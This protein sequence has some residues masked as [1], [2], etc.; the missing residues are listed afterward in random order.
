MAHSGLVLA[1]VGKFSGV[2]SRASHV[3]RL[4][5]T[6]S[7]PPF[8]ASSGAVE[9]GR[10]V[11]AVGVRALGKTP[12][13]R[14]QFVAQSFRV[15]RVMKTR[16]VRSVVKSMVS[17]AVLIACAMPVTSAQ[18]TNPVVPTLV[19]FSGMLSSAD[20]KPLTGIVGVT[21]ALYQDSG[22][23][24][25]LWME[26][27]NVQPDKNGHYSVQLGAA[28]S[29]GLPASVFASGEARWLGVQVQGE[30]EQPRVMLL[31]VPYALKAGDA[32]TLGEK[33]ASA[34][35]SAPGNN[36]LSP[37]TVGNNTLTGKGTKDYVPLWLSGSKLGNSKIFQSASGDLGVGTT[38]PAANLDVNGTTDIRNTLS[39]FPSGSA[40]TLSINGTAFSV[41]NT[42]TVTF[43]SGQ[44]F[45]GAGT[46]TGVTAGTGLTGGGTSGNVTLN[47]S[48]VLNI[49]AGTGIS[50]S[51][52][53]NPTVG[54]NTSVVPQLKTANTFTGN[55]MVNGNLSATGVVTGSGYQIGSNLFAFGSYGNGNAFL[56]FAGNTTATG[57][58]N[59]GTGYGALLSNST[60]YSNTAIG[61]EALPSNTTGYNNTASGYFALYANSTNCCNT[62][63]GVQALESNSADGN[64]AFGYQAL[65]SN[66]QSPT[67]S[68][69]GYQAL[70]SNT[71]GGLVGYD[72]T[73][74]GYG[75]LHANA[76][77]NEG[78]GSANTATGSY[79]LYDN[80]TG[81]SNVAVGTE[82][83]INNTTGTANTAVGTAALDGSNGNGLTCIGYNCTAG[84]D[85]LRNATAIGAHAVVGQSNSLVLGGTGKWAVNVGIGTTKPSNI[86]TIGRGL[87]H[88][89]SDS[90]ETYS[91]RRWKT[92]IKTLPDA[93]SK[94]EQLRGVSYDLKD[95]SKHEIGVIAEEVGAVVPEVVTYEDN[96]KDARGVDYSR[97]TALLIEATKEQQALIRK[98][99]QQIRAQQAQLKAQQAKGKLQ[100]AQVAELM[101]QV[102]AIQV[103]L[104]TNGQTGSEVR[105]V[106]ARVPLV[107]Q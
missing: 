83:L 98:Q 105:R 94:V 68:A 74:T 18:Q 26:T 43:V 25:P 65:L 88:P 38:T 76:G 55:Q 42:G 70:F 9:G 93:L 53:Q 78:E 3:R 91:S 100:D 36:S 89:V 52:G 5:F 41:S 58:S 19:N 28:S 62:A 71:G 82:A 106:K 101:S 30:A 59:T 79:A 46:I 67:N 21:F 44:T 4:N 48:G 32:Q 11:T 77:V 50:S 81:Y 72:N 35:L 99:Q 47:N 13:G 102:K 95:S 104:K 86:L 10:T 61:S 54:I 75:A 96:G 20:H 87:G 22:G 56:G 103:L 31:S 23:G 37:N 12:T 33:P 39:L 8:C 16:E 66:T 14:R 69:F 85:A 2:S 40:P 73:A 15:E 64:T 107:Q 84:R 27:Q 57:V 49:T 90:W 17:L 45:P 6:V 92:N 7:G 29:Q 34:F 97:L 1:G 63:M 24:A 60:G 80:T 51:G